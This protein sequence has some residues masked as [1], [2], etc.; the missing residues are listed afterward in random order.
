MSS[1]LQESESNDDNNSDQSNDSDDDDSDYVY[2]SDDS[3]DDNSAKIIQPFNIYQDNQQL[4]LLR[5]EMIQKVQDILAC[6]RDVALTFLESNKMT[7]DG[8]KMLSFLNTNQKSA[9]NG[10]EKNVV[11]CCVCGFGTATETTGR[12]C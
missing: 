8:E 4:N 2:E 10:T 5:D 1:L 6:S 3:G 12:A 11:G 9:T 7:T